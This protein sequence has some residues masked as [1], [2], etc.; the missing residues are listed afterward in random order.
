MSTIALRDALEAARNGLQWYR[1]MYPEADSGADDEMMAQIDEAL[2]AQPAAPAIQWPTMPPSRG[3]SSVLFDDGYAEGWAKCLSMCQ[4]AVSGSAAP[5]TEV[6]SVEP[7]TF[8]TASVYA[9]TEFRDA[10]GKLLAV[11]SSGKHHKRMTSALRTS[12]AGE[13]KP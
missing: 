13:V 2:A 6:P 9:D 3:Q 1:D 11:V 10:E 4:Q 5:A 8:T 7:V 12:L